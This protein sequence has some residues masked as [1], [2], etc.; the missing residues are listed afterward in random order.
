VE[1]DGHGDLGLTLTGLDQLVEAGLALLEP[2][3]PLV[4]DWAEPQLLRL[5]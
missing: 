2:R 4:P 5:G 3:R 1:L